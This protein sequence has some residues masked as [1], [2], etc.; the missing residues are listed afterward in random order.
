MWIKVRN[1]YF[2]ELLCSLE[3]R[4]QKNFAANFA[5]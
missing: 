2:V 5:N 3:F 4:V 1:P